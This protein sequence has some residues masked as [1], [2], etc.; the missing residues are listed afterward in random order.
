MKQ[1]LYVETTIVS[2]L[3]ARQ[4]GDAMR[5]SHEVLTRQWWTKERQRFDLYISQLVMQE[6]A[7]GN[8]TAAAERL[9]AL[10]GIPLLAMTSEIPEL[11]GQLAASLRL[12]PRARADAVHMAIAAVHRMSFLLTWNCRHLANAAL[13]DRI[14]RTCKSCGYSAPRIVTPEQLME[15]P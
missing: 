12:P 4:S 7:G 5:F 1:T 14:E 8:K 2:Y 15:R 6:A 3:T 9:K 13:A 11:A 10:N